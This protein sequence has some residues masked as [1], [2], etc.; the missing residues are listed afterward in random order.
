MHINMWNRSGLL[1]PQMRRSIRSS[2]VCWSVQIRC[3]GQSLQTPGETTVPFQTSVSYILSKMQPPIWIERLSS[4]FKLFHQLLMLL[5]YLLTDK[6]TRSSWLMMGCLTLWSETQVLLKVLSP[7][8]FC[9]YTHSC[10]SLKD[11][12][13]LIKSSEDAALWSHQQGA[14]SGHGRA[15]P[16]YLSI[17]GQM[18]MSFIW[19]CKLCIYRM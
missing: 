17:Y 3:D 1:L 5:L 13:Y 11:K 14:E 7:L 10:R 8:L 2:L 4:C 16:S 18:V 15:R 12:S 19:N 9:S 6:H